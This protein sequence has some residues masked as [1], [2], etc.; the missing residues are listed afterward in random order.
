MENKVV[1]VYGRTFKTLRV[2]LTDKCNFA[3]TYCVTKDFKNSSD[4]ESLEN[5]SLIKSIIQLNEVLELD[6]IR[7]TGGEPTLYKELVQLVSEISKLS[8]PL[9]LTTNGFLLDKLAEPLKKAG[10]TSVNI[11]LDALDQSSFLKITRRD[12]LTQVLNGIESAIEAGLD[13]KI[14]SVILNGIN[15][16]QVLPLFDYAKNMGISIRYLE[17]M[18]M[19]HFFSSGF[20]EYFF[21]QESILKIIAEKYRIKDLAR[22]ASATTHYWETSD[23]YKFGVI[24]NESTPFCNDCDRLR[25]DSKGNIYGCLSNNSPISILE[26]DAENS[27]LSKLKQA[28]EHKQ[29]A[30]FIGSEKSMIQFG[31]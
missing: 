18:R 4:S 21:S 24:A 26:I 25:L 28:L 15:D 11:S 22:G 17:L 1:D 30:K 14:N 6:A 5:T 16:D 20:E 12:S 7:F 27:L 8:I 29:P 3:C 13:V 10:L 31:G 23:G 2:S 9:K 19:G